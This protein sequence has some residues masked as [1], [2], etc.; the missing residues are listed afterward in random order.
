[1]PLEEWYGD[2]FARDLGAAS[3]VGLDA[4]AETLSAVVQGKLSRRGASAATLRR[5]LREIKKA[6]RQGFTRIGRAGRISGARRTAIRAAQNELSTG[7]LVDPPGG[8]PRLRTGVLA[9]STGYERSE[10]RRTLGYAVGPASVYG[11]VHEF[12]AVIKPKS[13]P[14]LVFQLLTGGW[15]KVKQVTVPAR[16]V[17]R[18]SFRESREAMF[19][20]FTSAAASAMSTD[21][22]GEATGG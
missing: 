9:R 11:P 12:G 17:W 1:M 22:G 13:A 8:H 4:A 20:A 21:A 18:P 6:E 14:W 19:E 15:V 5:G 10:G 3:E 7:G 16:P 2:D